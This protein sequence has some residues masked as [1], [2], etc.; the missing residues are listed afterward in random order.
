MA[1]RWTGYTSGTEGLRQSVESRA[2]RQYQSQEN[3]LNRAKQLEILSAQLRSQKQLADDRN[4]LTEANMNLQKE[5]QGMKIDAFKA[6]KKWVMDLMK[7]E[8]SE[9]EALS[10]IPQDSSNIYGGETIT[11]YRF[12]VNKNNWRDP[13]IKT[14]SK[15]GMALQTGVQALSNPLLTPQQFASGM[16]ILSDPMTI[17]INDPSFWNSAKNRKKSKET[18]ATLS[19]YISVID[20]KRPNDKNVTQLKG[21]FGQLEKTAL[22]KDLYYSKEEVDKRKKEKQ[23]QTINS[24]LN[25]EDTDYLSY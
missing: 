17:M 3:A 20:A 12:M 16:S 18:M 10:Y 6:E 21:L 13:L 5:L 8:A 15:E 11:D 1:Q 19:A 4:K 22:E 7:Q 14:S 2:N 25:M 9:K 23:I 24:I